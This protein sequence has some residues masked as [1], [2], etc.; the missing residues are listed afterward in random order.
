MKSLFDDYHVSATLMG[1]VDTFLHYLFPDVSKKRYTALLQAVH[2][3]RF[4]Y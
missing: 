2:F 4:T 1:N 3:T